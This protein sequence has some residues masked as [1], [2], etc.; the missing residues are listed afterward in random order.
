[1]PQRKRALEIS[2]GDCTPSEPGVT[3]VTNTDSEVDHQTKFLTAGICSPEGAPEA[4]IRYGRLHK[5]A[6]T[7]YRGEHY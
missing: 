2:A 5:K 6:N 3:G 7:L 4:Y 1:M